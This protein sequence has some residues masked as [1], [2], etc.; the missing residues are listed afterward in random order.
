MRVRASIWVGARSASWASR[1]W[2]RSSGACSKAPWRAV[3]R[4]RA[5]AMPCSRC[6]TPN[7]KRRCCLF[8]SDW[9]RHRAR[10]SSTTPRKLSRR[11]MRPAP[12]E[13]NRRRTGRRNG[14]QA[15]AH[16]PAGRRV[17]TSCAGLGA[18][19][20]RA[21]LAH[22]CGTPVRARAVARN[23]RPRAREQRSPPPV[24]ILAE[25]RDDGRAA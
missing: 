9:G 16:R 8:A 17:R 7:A 6:R 3:S 15:G 10:V 18:P 4:R 25:D 2:T 13:Q 19:H 1:A 14:R 11:R 22:C 5:P 20:R 24:G 23:A 12:L 21:R